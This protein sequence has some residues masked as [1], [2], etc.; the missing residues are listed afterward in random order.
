MA[1]SNDKELAE[2]FVL[3]GRT[4]ALAESCTGGLI[5]ARITALPGCSG[6]FRGGVIAYHN[7]I[8]QRLLGVPISLLEQHGA[9][10]EQV[11]CVMAEG[12][13]REIGSDLALA[14]TGIAGP[15]GGSPEKPVGTV[16]LALADD[17]GCV[18]EQY[19][20]TGNREQIRQQSVEQALFLIKSRLMVHEIV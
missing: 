11:A 19:H 18:T 16:Y 17:D 2:L 4:L 13:H 12:A 5:A 1:M 3:S 6:W 9:V 8:K 7:E 20:F 10:S 15:D 14:V